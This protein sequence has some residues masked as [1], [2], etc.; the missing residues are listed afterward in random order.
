MDSR[1]ETMVHALQRATAQEDLN[2]IKKNLDAVLLNTGRK[3]R[4]GLIN[5]I[6]ALLLDA[7]IEKN[8]PAIIRALRE[9]SYKNALGFL[10]RIIGHYLKTRDEAWL[11]EIFTL[12]DRLKT[13]SHQSYAYA[14]LVRRLIETGINTSDPALVGQG[15]RILDRVTI[16]KCRSEIIETIIPILIAWAGNSGDCEL[17][18]TISLMIRDIGNTAKR[19]VEFSNL[20]ETMATIAVRERNPSKF[21][22]SIKV[23]CNIQQKIRRQSCIAFVITGG[24]SLFLRDENGEISAFIDFFTDEPEEIRSEIICALLDDL[25]DCGNNYTAILTI[26]NTFI[27]KVPASISPLVLTL[28]KRAEKEGDFWYYTTALHLHTIFKERS[29]YP[30]R[31]LVRTGITITHNT[32]DPRPLMIIIP[33]V[34]T[35]CDPVAAS[36]IY[37]RIANVLLSMERLEESIEVLEKIGAGGQNQRLFEECCVALCRQAVISGKVAPVKDFL[38][39]RT[40]RIHLP[41]IL[42]RA[43]QDICRHFSFEMIIRHIDSLHALMQIHKHKDGMVLDCISMLI[44]R[45]FLETNDPDVL[46]SFT[47]NISDPVQKEQAL[48]S[49]VIEVARLGVHTRNRDSLQRAVGLTCLIEGETTR[50]S[51]LTMII[52]EATDLAVHD[53][54][55][56]LLRRMREWSASLL[57]RDI[58]ILAMAKIAE[59]MIKYAIDTRHPGALEEAYII[60]QEIGDISSNKELVDHISDSFVILG[61]LAILDTNYP[62]KNTGFTQVF[63]PFQRGLELLIMHGK[64]DDRS[65]RVSYF[66]DIILESMHQRFQKSFFFPL[67]LYVLEIKDPFERDAMVSRIV[68]SIRPQGLA[69][70]STDPY[71]VLANHLLSIQCPAHTSMIIDLMVPIARGIKDPFLR[72]LSML[73]GAEI[74]LR[75]NNRKKADGIL[76]E[77]RSSLHLVPSSHQK[78]ILLAGL[79]DSYRGISEDLAKKCLK[80]AVH[81]LPA[82]EYDQKSAA[83]QQVVYA[84]ARF[85]ETHQDPVYIEDALSV[86]SAIDNPSDYVMS[87]MAIFLMTRNDTRKTEMILAHIEKKCEHITEPDERA[88][89]LLSVLSLFDGKNDGKQLLILLD[90][91]AGI[92]PSISLVF[93][94]DMVKKSIVH[95][96]LNLG[97]TLHNTRLLNKANAVA[98]TIEYD[99]IRDRLRNANGQIDIKCSPTYEKIKNL[100]THIAAEGIDPAYLADLEKSIQSH[101]DRIK[102]IRYYATIY[103]LLKGQVH[104]KTTKHFMQAAVGEAVKIRPL[105]SRLTVL[106]DIAMLWHSAGYEGDAQTLM[107]YAVDATTNIRHEAERDS[108]FEKLSCA[109][110]FLQGGYL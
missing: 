43:S 28:L 89:I 38:E 21:I 45:G 100:T 85:N 69:T 88:L 41:D 51:T 54:D 25:C 50:S 98:Q 67:C 104:Q 5:Q 9:I 80:D 55:L 4:D 46:I 31:D 13:K 77:V 49:I 12:I 81:L 57:S 20:A 75:E 61:C 92:I 36:R 99:I 68:A 14:V 44:S 56:D 8:N 53:G 70:E 105:S 94:S 19:S 10:D 42:M 18:N 47:R 32:Q 7:S 91:I 83:L 33:L 15:I 64:K 97:E 101:P 40:D 24:S 17:L 30:T 84:I 107:D 87:M 2:V 29:R 78:V 82:V 3:K 72:L 23:A 52:N 11:T 103:I 86:A 1:S 102:R 16:R 93:I 22:E 26:L 6:N 62:V 34:A 96:Y 79:I 76:Q 73:Q 63:Q 60:A 48:S 108:G 65:I 109:I 74:C 95:L 37:I 59:G 110:K 35:S 39:K 27:K 71:E 58:E 90:R 106:C 66:I